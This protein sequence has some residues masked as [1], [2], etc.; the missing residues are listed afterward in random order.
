MASTAAG[1]DAG[2]RR[3]SSGAVGVI[4]FAAILMVIGGVFH[5]VQ[6]L[7]ALLSDGFYIAG[8][9]YI[10]QFSLTTWGWINLIVGALVLLAGIALF[11]GAMWARIVGV[12]LVSVSLVASF[13]WMPY[14]PLWSLTVVAFDLFVVWALT[15]HGKDMVEAEEARP[16]T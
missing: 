6:G 14:Y 15:A 3:F 12:I 1:G 8:E 2:H 11:Q 13:L 5:A 4:A 16:S 10:F 9:D 7:V